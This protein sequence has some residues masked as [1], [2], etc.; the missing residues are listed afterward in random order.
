MQTKITPTNKKMPGETLAAILHIAAWCIIALSV[1][2]IVT[3]FFMMN[4]FPINIKTDKLTINL[5]FWQIYLDQLIGVISTTFYALVLF[6]ISAII[7]AV[8]ANTNKTSQLT[9]NNQKQ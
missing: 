7:K 1:L 9:S 6:G 4:Y 2:R 3:P 8:N 5:S